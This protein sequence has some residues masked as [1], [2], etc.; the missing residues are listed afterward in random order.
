MVCL[1][2]KS[3]MIVL[4]HDEAPLFIRVHDEEDDFRSLATVFY[5]F[6]QQESVAEG[7]R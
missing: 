3:G 5:Q 7:L 4:D 1:I 2:S 6:W